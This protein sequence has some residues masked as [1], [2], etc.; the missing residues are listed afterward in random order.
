VHQTEPNP[1]ISEQF[2]QDTG[3][4]TTILPDDSRSKLEPAES[5]HDQQK[6]SQPEPQERKLHKH[7]HLLLY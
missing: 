7:N 3:Q 1:G 6:L 5:D 2:D 4:K